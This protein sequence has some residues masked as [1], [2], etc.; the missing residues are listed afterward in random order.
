MLDLVF[1]TEA[2]YSDYSDC[3]EIEA[4]IDRPHVQV[5]IQVGG[6]L[7]CVPLRSHIAHEYAFWTDKENRCGLD[8][9]KAV[10]IIDPQRY[11][12]HSRKPYLRK[13]DFSVLKST[14]PYEIS[15][16]LNLYIM[17]YKKAKLAPEQMRNAI[18]L[19]YSTLQYFEAYI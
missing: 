1:L 8:F 13:N 17:Q 6:Y 2:F 18:L 12:D 4:K 14:N 11:I 3:P 16:R 19:K 10:V 7:F 9:T 5:T 15:R